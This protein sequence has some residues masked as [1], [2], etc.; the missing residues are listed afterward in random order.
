MSLTVTVTLQDLTGA[1]NVGSAMFTLVGLGFA[2]R[3]A[4]PF[5]PF[6]FCSPILK[7]G[8]GVRII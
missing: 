1:A 8:N 3:R 6:S 5:S 2:P 4:E 7:S